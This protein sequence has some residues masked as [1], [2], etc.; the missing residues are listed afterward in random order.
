MV[1]IDPLRNLDRS[2]TRLDIA[3]GWLQK[4]ERLLGHL[5]VQFMYVGHIVSADADNVSTGLGEAGH[6]VDKRFWIAIDTGFGIRRQTQLGSQDIVNPPTRNSTFTRRLRGTHE[7]AGDFRNHLK[8]VKSGP[9]ESY[10]AS[11]EDARTPITCNVGINGRVD[12]I[13]RFLD[14]RARRQQRTVR[15]SFFNA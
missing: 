10:K 1:S 11:K 13:R 9:T 8:T 6:A 4:V 3:R 2:L 14:L 12:P 7:P 15:E 5:V